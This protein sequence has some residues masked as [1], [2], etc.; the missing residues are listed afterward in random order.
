LLATGSEDGLIKLWVLPEEGLTEH[1]SKCDVELAGHG[2][3]IQNIDWHKSVDMNIASTGLD[4]TVKIW[5][6]SH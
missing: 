2:A 6:V 1:I 4:N 5:D 3:K